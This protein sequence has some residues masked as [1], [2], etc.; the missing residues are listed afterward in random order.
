MSTEDL[1]NDL[2]EKAERAAGSDS[3]NQ[4]FY[5]QSSSVLGSILRFVLGFLIVFIIITVPLVVMLELIYINLPPVR[6]AVDK[7][8]LVGSGRVQKAAKITLRDATEAIRRADTLRTGNSA[9]VEYLKIKSKWIYL[10]MVIVV[11]VLGGGSII[12]RLLISVIS[13]ILEAIGAA[14][15]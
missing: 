13:G 8:V 12:L 10:T 9:T 11:M 5:L 1:V 3:V 2:T 6:E 15:A 4:L 7:K 14:L